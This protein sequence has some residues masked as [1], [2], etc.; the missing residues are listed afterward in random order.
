MDEVIDDALRDARS[1]KKGGVDGVMVENFWDAPFSRGRVEA[2]TVAAMTACVTEIRREVD[3][4]IGVNLLRNDALSALS[5]AQVAGARFIR[6]N[7]LSG[8]MVTDQG[9]IQ[10][11]SYEL[12]RLRSRLRADIV[13]MAD[14]MVKHAHPLGTADIASMARDTAY[15]GGADVLIVSGSETGAPLD[16]GELERVRRAVPE[17]P[18]AS[19]SGVTGDNVQD[20]LPL[21]DVL[22]IGTWFKEGGQVQKPVDVGRVRSMVDLMREG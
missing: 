18:I 9:I 5:V 3:I 8:A 11:C 10:G 2:V 1:L 21:L 22:I 4:P 17:F 16:I 14:V 6:V 15:R 19:G 12:S 20:L 7:V 13:I